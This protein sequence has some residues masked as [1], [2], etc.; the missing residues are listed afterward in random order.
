MNFLRRSWSLCFR[1]DS[2]YQLRNKTQEKTVMKN[3]HCS[4][5]RRFYLDFIGDF[6]V[7][8]VVVVAVVVIAAKT[9]WIFC[10][11]INHSRAKA[12][13]VCY[14][15]NFIISNQGLKSL[16]IGN[17]LKKWALKLFTLIILKIYLERIQSN[18]LDVKNQSIKLFEIMHSKFFSL[19]HWFCLLFF[20]PSI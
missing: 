19:A 6:L 3:I 16:W 15:L 12:L 17:S 9:D 13:T 11:E 2:F 20:Q 5:S 1:E 8:I 18:M 4:P 14:S 10:D 7:Y